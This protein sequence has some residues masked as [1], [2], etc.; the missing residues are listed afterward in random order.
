MGKLMHERAPALRAAIVR[1]EAHTS[2]RCLTGA[3][4]GG[5]SGAGWRQIAVAVIVTGVAPLLR[6][7]QAQALEL[8]FAIPLK[9][10]ATSGRS[11][12]VQLPESRVSPVSQPAPTDSPPIPSTSLSPLR[13]MM[14]PAR[15]GSAAGQSHAA[16]ASTSS[17]ESSPQATMAMVAVTTPEMKSARL[18]ASVM[19]VSQGEGICVGVADSIVDQ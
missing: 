19:E 7:P 8:P 18:R 15:G 9:T 12:T 3:R 16:W 6:Q 4:C 10:S 5:Y 11:G 1:S 17:G 14:R 13:W 2:T